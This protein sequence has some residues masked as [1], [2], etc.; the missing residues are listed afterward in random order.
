MVSKSDVFTATL[1]VSAGAMEYWRRSCHNS[2]SREAAD[3]AIMPVSKIKAIAIMDTNI[4]NGRCSL[5]CCV[6]LLEMD[7][8]DRTVLI[9]LLLNYL[10]TPLNVTHLP[11]G[12]TNVSLINGRVRCNKKYVYAITCFGLKKIG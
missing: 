3:D 8:R 11:M 10:L 6:E 2:S 9:V 1:S 12:N 5:V 7:L 4:R